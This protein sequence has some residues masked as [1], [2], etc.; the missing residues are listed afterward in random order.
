MPWDTNLLALL[1]LGLVTNRD[2][3]DKGCVGT[4][5]SWRWA[6]SESVSNS[7]SLQCLLHTKVHSHASASASSAE[8]KPCRPVMACHHKLQHHAPQSPHFLNVKHDQKSHQCLFCTHQER[9]LSNEQFLTYQHQHWPSWYYAP[10][11][12]V[13]LQFWLTHHR[14]YHFYS[15]KYD[16]FVPCKFP[17][18]FAQYLRFCQGEL[19]RTNAQLFPPS[20][21]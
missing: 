9:E 12:L 21:Q 20:H 1:I 18:T 7:Q 3:L 10:Y 17:T 8:S 5:Q 16:S 13:I 2:V 19:P 4:G 15:P 14:A 6:I 11:T